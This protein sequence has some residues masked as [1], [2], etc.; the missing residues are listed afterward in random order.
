M[1]ETDD[2]MESVSDRQGFTKNIGD[3]ILNAVCRKH[4]I[5]LKNMLLFNSQDPEGSGPIPFEAVTTAA[6]NG[7]YS[8]LHL[9]LKYRCPASAKAVQMAV[10]NGHDDCLDLLLEH[11]CPMNVHAARDAARYDNY[12]CLKLLVENNCPVDEIVTQTA[13]R[14]GSERCLIFLIKHGYMGTSVAREAMACKNYE[15]FSLLL[16][17]G[18]PIDD[19]V[20]QWAIEKATPT[21]IMCQACID[22]CRNFMSVSDDPDALMADIDKADPQATKCGKYR[23]LSG[24]LEYGW[25]SMTR[26]PSEI[27]Q[28]YDQSAS[29]DERYLEL[30]LKY[31]CPLDMDTIRLVIAREQ[32]KIFNLIYQDALKKNNR[33]R[34]EQISELISILKADNLL[35]QSV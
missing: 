11:K 1:T 9:L 24:N 8:I 4:Y 35:P 17:R 19:V 30:L 21:F 29:T 25:P 13:V 27:V 31:D 15:Y 7:D 14:H 16:D 32:Q 28:Q 6:S 5:N 34:L 20:A 22:K 3:A 26:P 10:Q 12:G 18:C 2:K 23:C 33:T